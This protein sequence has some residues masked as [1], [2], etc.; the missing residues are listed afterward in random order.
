VQRTINQS[1]IVRSGSGQRIAAVR[2]KRRETVGR[3]A[4]YI[5]AMSK[6]SPAHSETGAG[7]NEN[8]LI[9]RARKRQ[10]VQAQACISIPVS[11][12]SDASVLR[13]SSLRRVANVMPTCTEG[14]RGEGGQEAATSVMAGEI[15]TSPY[16]DMHRRTCLRTFFPCLSG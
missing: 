3:T 15:G 8:R 16:R 9:V 13:S 4:R 14:G 7:R 5:M 1:F 6:K 10:H 12:P 2:S 11:K